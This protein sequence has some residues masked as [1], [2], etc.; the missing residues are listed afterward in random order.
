[1]AAIKNTEITKKVAKLEDSDVIQVAQKMIKEHRESIAQFEKGGRADLVEKEKAELEI[2]Q[3]YV[4]AQMSEEETL[5]TVKAV[6]QELGAVS[7]AD[8]GKVMKAVMEKVKGKADGKLI[9]Q[10]VM[11]LLK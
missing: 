8:T 5:S 10:L 6:I 9:S 11:S 2:L 7:K 1:M 4:P 3:K